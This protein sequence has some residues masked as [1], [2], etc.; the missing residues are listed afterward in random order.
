M[1]AKKSTLLGDVEESVRFV[2][3]RATRSIPNFKESQ[4]VASSCVR[5]IRRA[6]AKHKRGKK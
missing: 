5:A 2:I 3:W 1:K 4:I 6:F